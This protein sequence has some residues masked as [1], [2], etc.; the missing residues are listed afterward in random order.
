MPLTSGTRLGAH[1]V[2]SSLGAG[3][4]GEVYRARDTKLGRDVALKILPDTFA[5][6]PERLAR[7]EREAKMLASLNHPHIAQIY[8]FEQSGST[9]A[10]VIEL[11]EGEDLSQRIA[12]GPIQLVEALTLAKQIAEAIEAAHEQGIV[13]RDLKPANIKIRDDGTVKVLDFGLAKALDPASGA[14]A[15]PIDSPTISG[16]ATEAGVILGTAAYMSPEQARGRTVDRRADL[17]AFGAVL[18]E[19]LTGRRAF[20]GDGAADTIARLLMEEPDWSALPAGT[21][22]PIGT[23]LRRCLEKDRRR[24]L[25]SAAAARFAIEDALAAPARPEA[26]VWRRRNQWAPIGWTALG[27]AAGVALWMAVATGR[28]PAANPQVISS[29]VDLPSSLTAF[30]SDRLAVSPDGRRLAFVAPGASGRNLLWIRPLSSLDA[31]PL[32]GTDGAGGPFWSP[33]SRQVGFSADGKLKRIDVSG[34]AVVTVADGAS[35]STGTWSRHDVILFSRYAAREILRVSAKGGAAEVVVASTATQ[36][37]PYYPFFLPDGR[38]FLYLR[39]RNVYLGSLGDSNHPRLIDGVGNAMFAS[40][41][42][43]YL[44]ETTLVAQPFDA[45]A[46]TFSG[47]AF[48]LAERIQINTGSGAGAFSVSESGVLIYQTTRASPSRLVWLDR[49]GRETGTLGEAGR[50]SEASLSADGSR[51]AVSMFGES[52][53]DRDIWLFDVRRG[54]RTR[55]TTDPTDDSDPLLSPDATRVVYSSRRGAVKG[56][57]VRDL[58]GTAG[59]ELLVESTF[60]KAPQAWSADGKVVLYWEVAAS[61]GRDL[62]AVPVAGDRKPVAVVRTDASESR[63][64]LSPDGRFL[65]Y[66]SSESGR[67]EVYIARFPTGGAKWPVSSTGGANPHWRRDG[68]EIY[69]MTGRAL[70]HAAVTT[71]DG[72]DVGV[73]EPLFDVGSRLPRAFDT[74]SNI[75][76]VTADGQRFLFNL[77]QYTAPDSLTLV[78]N[79]PALVRQ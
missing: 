1:E 50:Y 53:D 65:A 8:G 11:V 33:D 23:L 30:P 78:V 48:P 27:L 43:V 52:S 21:P 75:F 72:A 28:P 16:H 54:L 22:G 62:L 6:D 15:D 32:I 67:P 2:I 42:I 69:F 58:D 7:F 61:R 24:R 10:L 56:L 68:K 39:E 79:W 17:W 71:G 63:S 59:P 40:G 45:E 19:M 31:Q 35:S 57:Y 34:G 20:I 4:M 77:P 73:A 3:G 29:T 55:V 49:T 66:E 60:N 9:A 44:R 76:N 14:G 18:Y 38:R 12:R 70:M 64:D 5:S 46:L 13:H 36:P 26:P 74:H 47:G 51:V 37:L 25:D 41:H